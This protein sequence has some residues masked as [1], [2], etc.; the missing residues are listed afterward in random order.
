MAKNVNLLYK[1]STLIDV[2]GFFQEG[3]QKDPLECWNFFQTLNF[4]GV[5]P[6]RHQRRPN[7]VKILNNPQKSLKLLEDAQRS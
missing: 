1:M 4:V 2:H 6:L 7:R 3:G 5:V